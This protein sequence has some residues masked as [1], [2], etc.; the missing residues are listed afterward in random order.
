MRS[1]CSNLI[2]SDR[3]P[4]PRP[5][6]S[7]W[8]MITSTGT[9][10]CPSSDD[11]GGSHQCRS[12]IDGR[13]R[14]VAV[15][16]GQ[17]LPRPLWAATGV[18]GVCGH[19]GWGQSGGAHACFR[20]TVP[21]LLP[22]P[23]PSPLPFCGCCH[24]FRPSFSALPSSHPP[25]LPRA[26]GHL[27]HCSNS[28]ASLLLYHMPLTMLRSLGDALFLSLMRGGEERLLQA[29]VLPRTVSSGPQVHR[30]LR[31]G[32]RGWRLGARRH[33][34]ALLLRPRLRPRALLSGEDR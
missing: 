3:I 27:L 24:N 7:S 31:L 18:G 10:L 5:S 15:P 9:R 8:P 33:R 14:R 22:V 23:P 21:P 2:G 13:A 32:F 4:P 16:R 19:A 34:R 28:F 29:V 17:P 25:P 30:S 6:S 20:D 12:A 1:E 26:G 11:D